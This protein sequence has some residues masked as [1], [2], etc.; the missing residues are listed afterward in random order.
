M[1]I[2]FS[3]SEEK[4]AAA[5][6]SGGSGESSESAVATLGTSLAPNTTSSPGI[7]SYTGNVLIVYLYSLLP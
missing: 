2:I 7:N 5:A 4:A 3:N 6:K 1:C